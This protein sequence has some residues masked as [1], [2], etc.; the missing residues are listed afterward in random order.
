MTNGIHHKP[1][2]KV[3]I[4]HSD[5]KKMQ[6]SSFTTEEVTFRNCTNRCSMCYRKQTIILTSKE[7]KE[8][9][10]TL[11]M[12]CPSCNGVVCK[13]CL[14]EGYEFKKPCFGEKY[15]ITIPTATLTQESILHWSM[16]QMIIGH[17]LIQLNKITQCFES[18]EMNFQGKI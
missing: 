7:K 8:N 16:H 18:P 1:K 9:W 10:N 5:G 3:V 4:H 12:G 17:Y 13:K 15:P 6:T 11:W 2:A 14:K